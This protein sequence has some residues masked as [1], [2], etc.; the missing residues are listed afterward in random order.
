MNGGEETVVGADVTLGHR[1]TLHG[2]TI[3][4]RV[5]AGMGAIVPMC[6]NGLMLSL[7]QGP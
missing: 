5:L 2:C 4:D 3:G 1:V 6:D 7:R